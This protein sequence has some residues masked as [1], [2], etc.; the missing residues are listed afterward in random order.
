MRTLTPSNATERCRTAH[1][2]LKMHSRRCGRQVA[3]PTMRVGELCRVVCSSDY[4][5]GDA[6]DPPEIPPRA[7][8][9]FEMELMGVR[10][11]LR[12]MSATADTTA[13]DTARRLE[14]LKLEREREVA[15]AAEARGDAAQRKA[16]AKA[17]A[18]ERLANKGQKKGGK[19]KK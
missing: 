15:Q 9:T 4:G 1:S 5:Y 2:L 18:A 14:Q 10:C 19:K 6:G 11:M 3:V 16:A 7:T 12:D 8:L 13:R 17:A